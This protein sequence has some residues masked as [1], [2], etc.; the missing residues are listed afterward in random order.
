MRNFRVATFFIGMLAVSLTAG[1]TTITFTSRSAWQAALAGPITTIDFEGIA[2]A[3]GTAAFSDLVLSGV[4][5]GAATVADP[6]VG[7]FISGW[8]TGAMIFGDYGLFAPATI[9][10]ASPTTAFGFNYGAT[11]VFFIDC[12]PARV[13]MSLSSGDLVN[14]QGPIPPM[15]FVGVISDVPLTSFDVRFAPS[16]TV[17]DNFSYAAPTPVPEPTTL[18]LMLTGLSGV[19]TSRR[20]RLLKSSRAARGR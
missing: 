12:S 7:I 5:F 19:L 13:S 10:F 1:A 16:L 4:D 3:N 20:A 14:S 15:A 17:L 11:C 8:G 18:V 2:P 9:K 6:G